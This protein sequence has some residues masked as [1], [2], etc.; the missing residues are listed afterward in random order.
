MILRREIPTVLVGG[1]RR[2]DPKVLACWYMK[3][4]PEAKKLRQI[5]VQ[6]AAVESVKVNTTRQ[7]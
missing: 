4:S 1:Q 5:F 6:T 2:F 7:S 3:R